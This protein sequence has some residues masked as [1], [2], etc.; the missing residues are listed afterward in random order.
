MGIPDS[1]FRKLQRRLEAT[2]GLLED[3]PLAKSPTL[4]S[5]LAALQQKQVGNRLCIADTFHPLTCL[6][7]RVFPATAGVAVGNVHR[8]Q[9]MM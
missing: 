6:H 9:N 7:G 5:R 8:M 1:G 3:H 2:E 4:S